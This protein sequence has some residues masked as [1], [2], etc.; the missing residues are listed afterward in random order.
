MDKQP[1]AHRKAQSA[2]TL[3]RRRF[4]KFGAAGTGLLSVSHPTLASSTSSNS[5]EAD[6]GATRISRYGTLGRTG[7]ELSDISFGTSRLRSGQ[8]DLVR[9]ALDKGVNYFD[10]ADSYTRGQSENVLGNALQGVRDQI[11]IVSK[12]RVGANDDRGS[13]MQALEGSLKRLKTDYVDVFFNHAVNDVDRL[14]NSEWYEFAERA[15]AQGKIR[16]TGM[17]GH[18]GRL[19]NVL[20]H[21]IGEDLVDVILVSYNFG[22]DPAFYESLTRSFDRI[23]TQ[24]GLPGVLER[25]KQKNIGV[26]AMKTLMGARLN[27]MRDYEAAGATFAQAAFHWTLANPNVD[28][29]IIS[30]T[31]K[32]QID[33]YLGASGAQQVSAADL[34]LLHQ[35]AALNGA[36]YCRQ[37]CNDC[38]GAC[39]YGVPIADVLRT[40][41]YATDYQDLDFARLEYAEL[42]VNAQACLSCS[43]E[44]CQSACSHGLEVSALCAPTHRMLA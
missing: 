11:A 20:D 24:S 36:T 8:E 35:Y 17:S 42:E 41:M 4:L 2:P 9:H 21:A 22:Q 3:D 5:R 14:N 40:R 16:F 43:G 7:I 12:T 39:P 28:A 32:A 27:D 38:E 29:L 25:A 34:K 1:K 31:S 13:I 37:A 26:V 19:V 30:M 18:A 15:R 6:Y 10:T 33:E 44:P 23:A